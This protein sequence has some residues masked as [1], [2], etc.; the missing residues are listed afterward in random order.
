MSSKREKELARMRAERQATRRAQAAAERQKRR[1]TLIAGLSALAVAAVV[2]VIALATDDDKPSSQNTATPSATG[3]AG[4]CTYTKSG[5]ASKKVDGL[6][7][8]D[9]PKEK[10]PTP[11]KFETNRGEIELTLDAAKAPCTVNSFTF[12]T[13]QKYFDGTSCHRLTS[14]GI[15]VLQCGDPTALGTGGPGY[16]MP[17]E[18]LTAL[19]APNAQGQVIYP[20]GTIAMARSSQPG[21]GGSQFFLVYKDSPLKPDYT[22]FGTITKGLDLLD[23]VAKAGSTPPNDGKPNQSVTLEKV[24]T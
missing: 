19:G 13:A 7:S 3:S 24:T 5:E 22:P 21:S 11:V 20:R 18:N 14:Q 6:P 15:F 17:E 4:A 1:N 8:A 16:G 12:L 9:G 23:A 2:V 10:A